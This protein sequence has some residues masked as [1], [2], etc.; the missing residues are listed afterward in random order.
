MARDQ[1]EEGWGLGDAMDMA[2]Y[3]IA[4]EG[5]IEEFEEKAC[6]LLKKMEREEDVS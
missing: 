3:F 5:T 4:N 6:E 1:R 2:D